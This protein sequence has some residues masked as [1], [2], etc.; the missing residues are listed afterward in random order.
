MIHYTKEKGHTQKT[1]DVI[2]MKSSKKEKPQKLQRDNGSQ[3][4]KCFL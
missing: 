2:N 1:N 3:G 4:F